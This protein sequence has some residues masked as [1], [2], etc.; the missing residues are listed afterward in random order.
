MKSS[1]CNNIILSLNKIYSLSKQ[2]KC[3]LFLYEMSQSV[4]CHFIMNIS[5]EKSNR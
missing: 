5:F 1:N 3:A 2:S 4:S